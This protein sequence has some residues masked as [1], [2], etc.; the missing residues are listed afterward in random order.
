MIKDVPEAVSLMLS[1]SASAEGIE[2]Q[3]FARRLIYEAAAVQ[4]VEAGKDI[5]IAQL[6]ANMK[7]YFRLAERQDIFMADEQ[8]EQF[9]LISIDA[10]NRFTKT[11]TRDGRLS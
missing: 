10:F 9:V 3:E 11:M 4:S 5:T 6:Q 8:G 1:S 2:V 7:A